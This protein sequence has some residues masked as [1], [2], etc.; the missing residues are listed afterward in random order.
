M[1]PLISPT[2]AGELCPQALRV[3]ILSDAAP[4][5][6]G[7]G[8]YYHDLVE[9]LERHV[10]AIEMISPTID[11]D[12]RWDAGLVLPLPG[13][14][15]QKLCLPR[16]WKLSRRLRDLRPH[17]VIAATPGVY[18]V[19]GAFLAAR[20]RIPIL[21]GLH[22]SFEQLTELYWPDSCRG[23]IVERY[24]R[25]SNGYLL[26]HSQ[27][28]LGN[29]ASILQQARAM[30]AREVKLIGTPLASDFALP[31]LRPWSGQLKALLFAGRLAKEKNLDAVLEAA[32]ALPELDFSIAGDGPLRREVES[33]AAGLA[34]LHYLGWL[35]REELREAVDQHDALLLPSFFETFGTI[36][37]EAMG[38]ERLAVVSRGC[39]IS[40][41]P[42]LQQ[43]LVVLE[44]DQSLVECLNGLLALNPQQRLAIAREGC[45]AARALN[46]EVVE[47]WQQLLLDTVREYREAH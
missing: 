3:M 24:F 8:A 45:R 19:A 44:Q 46:D 15:T 30:G 33:A 18:G 40:D 5:R 2:P 43:G 4:S 23:R 38:R 41:W 37:L 26:K 36:A 10:E 25:F 21:M 17:V 6:N 11:A 20:R 28:V 39:G 22:T 34:N 9:Q 1:T 29:S 14:P 27:A 16:L 47:R 12:G 32:A 7:V 42:S 31:P 13:D 35:S